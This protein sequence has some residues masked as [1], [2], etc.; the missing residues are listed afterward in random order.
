M[1]DDEI[2]DGVL[3]A[4]VAGGGCTGD[5]V[6]ESA[7]EIGSDEIERLEGTETSGRE[8]TEA[9]SDGT[10]VIEASGE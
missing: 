8:D 9:G 3:G 7:T 2:A 4:I 6:G 1:K 5:L 10:G